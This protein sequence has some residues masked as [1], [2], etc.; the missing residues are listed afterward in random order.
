MFVNLNSNKEKY[1]LGKLNIIVTGR[2]KEPF[3][4]ILKLTYVFPKRITNA[5]KTCHILCTFIPVI[6]QV[7]FTYIII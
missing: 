6:L 4:D 3:T 7:I 1:N 2:K 5:R